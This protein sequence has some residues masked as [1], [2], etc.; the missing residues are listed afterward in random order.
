MKP[1]VNPR[2]FCNSCTSRLADTPTLV[3]EATW[4]LAWYSCQL[5]ESMS[6]PK[7]T[8]SNIGKMSIS[9]NLDFTGN[10]F[11]SVRMKITHDE[12]MRMLTFESS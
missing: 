10:L 11:R 2:S 12:K 1:A 6:E 4:L 8:I 9:I 5:L 7:I 3:K